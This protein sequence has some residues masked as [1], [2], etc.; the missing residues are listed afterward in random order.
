MGEEMS[1]QK[2]ALILGGSEFFWGNTQGVLATLE[3][4]EGI[5]KGL[6]EEEGLEGSLKKDEEGMEACGAEMSCL[7]ECECDGRLGAGQ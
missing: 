6:P 7:A 4:V 1:P 2:E 5:S 3:I